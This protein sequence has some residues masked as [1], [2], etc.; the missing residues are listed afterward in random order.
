[1]NAQEISEWLD[2][3]FGDNA[4]PWH[5]CDE[6]PEYPDP[7]GAGAFYIS[8]VLYLPRDGDPVGGLA[9]ESLHHWSDL[10]RAR[11]VDWAAEE[12]FVE[13]IINLIER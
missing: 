8:G 11:V 7:A 12:N 9:H 4:P 1:M 6:G 2:E 10:C 3:A 5:Y 13:A